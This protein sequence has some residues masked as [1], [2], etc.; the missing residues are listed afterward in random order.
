MYVLKLITDFLSAGSLL[1]STY[2]QA[3]SQRPVVFWHGM[4]DTYNSSAMQNVFS[5]I[6]SVKPNLPI[7]SV[8]ID[9][10]ES[11]DQQASL[12]GNVNEQVEIVCSQIESIPEL[13]NQPF[14]FIGF[15]QGGVFAR[16]AIERCGLNVHTLITFGSPHVGVSDLPKCDDSDWLCKRKNEILKKQV[17]KSNVQNSIVA[18]Q[19]FRD[20]LDYEDYLKHSAFLVDVNNELQGGK[21]ETYI[22]NF[23]TLEKLI[24]IM[25]DK[26][27]TLVPKESAWFYDQDKSSGETIEFQNTDFYQNELIGLKSLFTQGKIE[28]LKINDRHM[29]IGEDFLKMITENYLGL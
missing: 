6:H 18:A 11:K 17:W 8:F 29:S 10:D 7:Y 16:A 4:G 9:Q 23:E 15:S 24:L 22:E 25:F 20:P 27:E 14:D 28:F 13:N 1:D 2:N 26:D 19:Y 21:N 3:T 5:T 12:I